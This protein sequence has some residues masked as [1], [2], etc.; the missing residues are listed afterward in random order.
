MSKN[1]LLLNQIEFVSSTLVLKFCV[2]TSFEPKNVSR[3]SGLASLG[4][5][6]FS[7]IPNQ[8]GFSIF[9]FN[10]QGIILL[11]CMMYLLDD[12]EDT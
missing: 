4:L 6:T 1:K 12:V 3:L 9:W 7:S 11:R 2:A 8:V 10:H 5:D